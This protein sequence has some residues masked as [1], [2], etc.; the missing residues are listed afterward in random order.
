MKKSKRKSKEL[1]F[2]VLTILN[3]LLGII[4]IYCG[5]KSEIANTEYYNGYDI[6]MIIIVPFGV[7]ISIILFQL[8]KYYK[9]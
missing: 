5:I 1:I 4:L 9:K 7:I 3:T 2:K 8:M 6:I